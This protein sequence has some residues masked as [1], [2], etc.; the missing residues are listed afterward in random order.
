M[1]DARLQD[2]QDSPLQ[3]RSRRADRVAWLVIAL[4]LIASVSIA[5]WRG[6]E[7]PATDGERLQNLASALQCP[8]CNGLSVLQSESPM[9]K[10]SREEI[11]NQIASGRSDGEIRTFFVERYGEKTWVV[12]RKEG[13]EL[14]VWTIPVVLG[15][16]LLGACVLYV[17]RGWQGRR[18][19]GPRNG[20][21]S[22]DASDSFNSV[23]SSGASDSVGVPKVDSL[24]PMWSP[25]KK[26]VVTVGFVVA[27]VVV[28]GIM[29]V[30]SRERDAKSPEILMMQA[31]ERARNNEPLDAIKA[32]DELL[33]QQ[34]SN[35][36]AL[37]R[38]AW[39]LRLAGLHHEAKDGLDAA[40]R[41]DQTLVEGYYYRALLRFEDLGDAEGARSD[42]AAALRYLPDD[43][44][45]SKAWRER[46]EG[47]MGAEGLSGQ[48]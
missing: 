1:S 39:L 3:G 21:R 23:D 25:R 13:A 6:I 46:L 15:V 28:G 22:S 42:A 36:R 7:N 12:P 44:E 47:L 32:Y 8:T 2:S 45:A 48:G 26:L 20:S 38:R 37:A 34:P 31:S 11:A 18:A 14:L 24:T 43:A 33:A 30:I 35:A 16:L 29:V 4:V 10:A 5:L 27:V 19:G 9:A 17:R 41:L 40:L